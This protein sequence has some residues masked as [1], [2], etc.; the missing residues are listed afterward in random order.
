MI[1][2]TSLLRIPMSKSPVQGMTSLSLYPPRRVPKRT[3]YWTEL[4]SIQP[5]IADRASNICVLQ[6]SAPWQL[7]DREHC[8]MSQVIGTPS[9]RKKVGLPCNVFVPPFVNILAKM[10]PSAW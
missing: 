8:G 4:E 9:A 3:V 6:H 7:L 1:L 5:V 10:L 2:C